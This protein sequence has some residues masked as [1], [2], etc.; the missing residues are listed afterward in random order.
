MQFYSRTTAAIV[1]AS[2]LALSA[3]SHG[4]APT[5]PHSSSSPVVNNPTPRYSGPTSIPNKV[6][7]RKHVTM[8]SCARTATG[9][10]ASGTAA[11]AGSQGKALLSTIFCITGKGTVTASASTRAAVA[12]HKIRTCR[13]AAAFAAPGTTRCVLRGVA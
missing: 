11:V 13:A 2:A 10:A 3:C 4:G 9:W 8:T 7:L 1:V 12:P 6:D 5:K